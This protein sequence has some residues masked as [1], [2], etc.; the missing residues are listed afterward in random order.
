MVF[1]SVFQAGAQPLVVMLLY[2][3]HAEGLVRLFSELVGIP[4]PPICHIRHMTNA[5][6]SRAL[7]RDCGG[8]KHGFLYAHQQQEIPMELCNFP[9]DPERS[10]AAF[11]SRHALLETIPPDDGGGQRG[12]P[13]SQDS[14]SQLL[15]W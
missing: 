2:Q 5:W 15:M 3:N 14:Y 8:V 12:S 7:A 9:G 10:V 6:Y 13:L 4:Q 1:K 11:Q